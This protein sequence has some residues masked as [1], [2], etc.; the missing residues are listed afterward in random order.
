[1]RQKGSSRKAVV[2][3]IVFLVVLCVALFC[4]PKQ[5]EKN[6]QEQTYEFLTREGFTPIQAS[7]I[8]A[9][10]A[11]QSNFDCT[12]NDYENIGQGLLMWSCNRRENLNAFAQ[13]AGKNTDDWKTQMEFL[14]EE[15][16][17]ET[18]YFQH[19]SSYEGYT[20]ENF[21]EAKNPREAAESF[22]MW[23]VM[24]GNVNLQLLGEVAEEFYATYGTDN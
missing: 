14:V 18:Q 23:Y 12:A 6:L 19:P 21:L 15:M 22:C 4:K 9:T 2:V 20:M 3:V 8:M 7:G 10:I 1:M 11:L 17:P 24:P 5:E 16:N 13:E